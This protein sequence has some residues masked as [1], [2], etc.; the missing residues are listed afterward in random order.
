MMAIHCNDNKNLCWPTS[1][2]GRESRNISTTNG[3]SLPWWNK[4]L[5]AFCVLVVVFNRRHGVAK[6]QL[7]SRKS[8]FV[9][10]LLSSYCSVAL[11]ELFAQWHNETIVCRCNTHV[12]FVPHQRILFSWNVCQYQRTAQIA[13]VISNGDMTRGCAIWWP[14]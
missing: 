5:R 12:S 1:I 6:S 7:W 2:D 3:V 8:D 14:Y 10:S 9:N 11:C 4:I 13:F